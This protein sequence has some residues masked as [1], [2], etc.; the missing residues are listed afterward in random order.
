MYFEN[1][2]P[3]SVYRDLTPLCGNGHVM[4]VQSEADGNLYVKKRFFCYQPEIYLQ[5][6]KNP[7]VHTPEICGIYEE[8]SEREGGA[9]QLTV[10]EEYLP[11]ITI[12]ERLSEGFL[13]SE[14][15]TVRIGME[16]CQILEE[17]HGRKPPVIHRDIKP[18]NI[19][20]LP[21]GSV[22]LLDFN[23]AKTEDAGKSRDT[24]LLGTAGFAAPEQYGFSS[25]SRQTDIYGI[26]VLMNVMLTGRFPS[27][28]LAD[29]KIRPM[30]RRC[31]EMN[32]TDRYC[33]VGELYNEL[34]RAKKEKIR[35][36][37]PGFR[38]LS[39]CRMLPAAAGYVFFSFL[40]LFGIGA[41]DFPDPLERRFFQFGF[42]LMLFAA[43]CFYGDYM[44][45][46]RYFPFMR[47]SSRPVRILG[48]ILAPVLIFWGVV[49][50]LA[51]LELLFL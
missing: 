8:K 6:Q 5:L 31:L 3:L 18:S 39:P 44:G 1:H 42:F 24:V 32:P 17:L 38:S 21:E 37:P 12:E 22:I 13:F 20:I 45:V 11:G 41:E 48:L 34:G 50:I 16:L 19:L 4:L 23:A 25:A 33:D 7:A 36:F 43:V 28:M 2:Y 47:S 51:M 29:G 26:G 27:E 30:I 15:E 9:V 40:F 10:I 49:L 46:R 35:W 14:E